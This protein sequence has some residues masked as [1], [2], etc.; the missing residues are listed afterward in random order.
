VRPCGPVPF[1]VTRPTND[2]GLR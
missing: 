1:A 2:I